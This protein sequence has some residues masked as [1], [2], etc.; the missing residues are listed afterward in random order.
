MQKKLSKLQQEALDQIGDDTVCRIVMRSRH[1]DLGCYLLK[2][3]QQVN[4]HAVSG[5]IRKG[6]IHQVD[7]PEKKPPPH[8]MYYRRKP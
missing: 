3:N 8:S 5:L 7:C 6:L 1:F 2:A 4:S